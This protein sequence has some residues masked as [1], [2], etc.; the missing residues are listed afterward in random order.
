YITDSAFIIGDNIQRINSLALAQRLPTISSA[1]YWPRLGALMSYGANPLV[2]FLA[3]FQHGL[4]HRRGLLVKHVQRVPYTFNDENSHGRVAFAQGGFD[5]ELC[6]ELI[7]GHISLNW[8]GR[9][10]VPTGLTRRRR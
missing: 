2:L 8:L 7:P 9:P 1:R 10:F 5:V 6:L 3:K 4:N